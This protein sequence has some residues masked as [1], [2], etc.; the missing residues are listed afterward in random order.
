[1]RNS[2]D[3]AEDHCVTLL[4]NFVDYQ[5]PRLFLGCLIKQRELFVER[6][7]DWVVLFMLSEV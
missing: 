7:R 3:T 5:P 4:T 2:L 6:E 1:M